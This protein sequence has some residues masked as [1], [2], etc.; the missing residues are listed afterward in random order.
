MEKNIS[1]VLYSA[2][3]ETMVKGN[4]IRLIIDYITKKRGVEG[5]HKLLDEI[6]KKEI[7]FTKETDIKN[8]EN[9]PAKYFTRT[10]NSA[11]K[12]LGDENLVKEMGKYFGEHI[13]MSFK[14][15][16]GRYPPKKSVQYM[17]IYAR[18][19]LPVFHTGYRTISENS[20]WIKTSR[21]NKKIYPFIDGFFT[22]MFKTHGGIIEVKKNVTEDSVKYVLKF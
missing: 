7:L 11:I 16:T 4:S 21:I 5:L 3:G 13:S 15:V 9:Y 10:L 8:D 18:E 17:V 1:D 19:N 14:S 12:I 20:Y 2:M 22:H 6:N